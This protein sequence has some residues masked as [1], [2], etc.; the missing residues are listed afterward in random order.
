M[1]DYARIR[2]G[3][4]TVSR[5]ERARAAATNRVMDQNSIHI[6]HQPQL[7]KIE[8]HSIPIYTEFVHHP[9]NFVAENELCG[10]SGVSNVGNTLH[11]IM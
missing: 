7:S 6:K 1:F 11:N 8:F 4:C 2:I 5:R 10:Q 9:S 3:V